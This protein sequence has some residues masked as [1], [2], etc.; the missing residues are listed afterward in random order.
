MSSIYI[1]IPFCKQACHYCDFHFSTNLKYTDAMSEAINKELYLRKEVMLDP[2]ETI[3]FGGGTPSVLSNE[4]LDSIIQQVYRMYLV[5]QDAE[6]TLEANPD[7]LNPT[8]LA[9]LARL[10]I[11]RLSVG[12]Q[13][14][15]DQD[16]VWMNRAHT[17]QQANDLLK[18]LPHVFENYTVDLIYGI[19]G[20]TM[21]RWKENLEQLAVFNPPHFSAYALTVEPGTALA[22]FIEKGKSPVVSEVQSLNH[23][24]QLQ[25]FAKGHGY[26]NYEFSNFGKLG[27]Y[28]RNNMAYWDGKSY[29]GIGPG[30]HSFD[31]IRRSWNVSNNPTYIKSIEGGQL[32]CDGEDL[33]LVDRYNEY[34]MTRLRTMWGID[35]GHVERRFGKDF[36]AYM[37]AQMSDLVSTG[38]LEFYS[39]NWVVSQQS[40]FLTDGI[41]S[42]LFYTD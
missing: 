13:S 5:S 15:F 21:V 33:S 24:K 25:A 34:V 7:D 37:E 17:A 30:A 19:P 11:N 23:Y 38:Q 28:S 40:K 2:I 20:M 39:G 32:P 16:L 29:L 18:A 36:R 12:V 1:H 4:Q 10:G 8:R 27:F 14:F 31:G 42:T 41:A 26:Q 3:Y 6:I 35:P 9:G 22:H